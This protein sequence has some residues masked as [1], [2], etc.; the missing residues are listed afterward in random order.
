MLASDTELRIFDKNLTSIESIVMKWRL[1][2]TTHLVRLEDSQLKNKRLMVNWYKANVHRANHTNA[3]NTA[4]R[5]ESIGTNVWEDLT[6][7]R[8]T[9]K[10]LLTTGINELEKR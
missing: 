2:L 9:W 10:T 5:M 8:S 1:R 7:E 3:T 6:S 4:S